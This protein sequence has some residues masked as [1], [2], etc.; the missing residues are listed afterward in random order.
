[1]RKATAAED[2]ETR[3]KDKNIRLTHTK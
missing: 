1:L 2:S 3:Q